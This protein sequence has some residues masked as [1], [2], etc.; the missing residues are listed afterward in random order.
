MCWTVMS[1]LAPCWMP[2]LPSSLCW[3]LKTKTHPNTATVI[4]YT[5]ITHSLLSL[6]WSTILCHTLLTVPI[7][8]TNSSLTFLIPL[9]PSCLPVLRELS[10]KL[11]TPP[12]PYRRIK[13]TSTISLGLPGSSVLPALHTNPFTEDNSGRRTAH[14]LPGQGLC[15]LSP[16]STLWAL[17]GTK[18]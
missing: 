13:I 12:K 5:F 1:F 16:H 9:L 15:T 7:C 18:P 2:A 14:Q 3:V 6:P 17:T 11:I 10:L 4:K 8:I